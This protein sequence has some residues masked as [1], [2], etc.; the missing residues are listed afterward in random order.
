MITPTLCIQSL[1][2]FLTR[3]RVQQRTPGFVTFSRTGKGNDE[4]RCRDQRFLQ[5]NQQKHQFSDL[6]YALILYLLLLEKRITPVKQR[7][8]GLRL[9]DYRRCGS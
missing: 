1:R 9:R 7:V 3:V 4:L 2:V 6:S 5:L 8:I